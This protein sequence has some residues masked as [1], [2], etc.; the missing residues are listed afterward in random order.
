[1]EFTSLAV[2][3][4]LTKVESLMARLHLRLRCIDAL[5]VA[6]QLSIVWS[7]DG[8]W[9]EAVSGARMAFTLVAPSS[10]QYTLCERFRQRFAL[11]AG[12]RN[13]SRRCCA[14][15]LCLSDRLEIR[16]RRARRHFQSVALPE[17]TTIKYGYNREISSDVWV[18]CT[19]ELQKIHPA[20]LQAFAV[21]GRP[22]FYALFFPAGKQNRLLR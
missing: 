11:A 22:I 13:V 12:V 21:N 2:G 19:K 1:M 15:G 8:R 6:L 3:L 4:R 20:P 10:V 14:L 16:G 17:T 18:K 7:R 9:C 5:N